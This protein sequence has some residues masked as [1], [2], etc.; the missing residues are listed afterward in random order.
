MC[1]IRMLADD[2]RLQVVLNLERSAA[3]NSVSNWPGDFAA[4]VVD[5]WAILKQARTDRQNSELKNAG[6]R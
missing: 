4:W 1:P 3:I 2:V 5:L 6:S